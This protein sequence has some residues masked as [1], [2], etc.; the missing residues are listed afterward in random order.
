MTRHSAI[1]AVTVDPVPCA[2]TG[3]EG[4]AA[5]SRLTATAARTRA[6]TGPV[7]TTAS[8]VYPFLLAVADQAAW[9]VQFSVTVTVADGLMLVVL[10][11]PVSVALPLP[12]GLT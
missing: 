6:A 7:L 4:A 9:H 11:E 12:S 3:V 5:R 10:L 1:D 8:P 2:E